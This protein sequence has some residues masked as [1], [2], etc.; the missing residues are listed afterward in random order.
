[1]DAIL[2]LASKAGRDVVS[3]DF[4]NSPLRLVRWRGPGEETSQRLDVIPAQF[5]ILVTRRPRIA[6]IRVRE[7]A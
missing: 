1:M 2:L 7:A 5:R 4:S 3:P 6:V